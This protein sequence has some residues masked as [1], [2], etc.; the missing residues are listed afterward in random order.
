MQPR[1]RLIVALDVPDAAG[2]R[3]LVDQLAGHVGLFKVG[4]QLF[5]A[6]G[7]DLVREIVARGERVFLDLKYHDIPNTVAGAV[8]SASRLGVTLLDV[9]GLG[10]RA[11]M[12]AAAGARAGERPL[13]LAI[14]VL[15]S[16]DEAALG[17]IGLAGPIA[18][19][20]PRLARLA[21]A[22]GLDGVVASPHEVGLVRAACGPG[23]RIVTPGIRPAGAAKGD[24]A[25]LATPSAALAAGADYLVVGRPITEAAVPAAAAD[26]IVAEMARVPGA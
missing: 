18:A 12:E 11:M 21:A 24:Q 8:A 20:V 22:S 17:E 23:F 25:R 3:T 16:H 14:T 19:A 7:P 10:G 15:T 13:L 2:A 26:A 4:S 1:E 6:A 5:T 9:H